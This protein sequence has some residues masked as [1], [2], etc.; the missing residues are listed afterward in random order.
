MIV[1][2]RGKLIQKKPTDI[3][4]DVGGLGYFCSISTNTY[5]HL[6]NIGNEVSL[7]TYFHVMETN[8]S[9]FAFSLYNIISKDPMLI[10]L[11]T[12]ICY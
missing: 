3:I 2:I 7:L 11:T 9:L 12:G 8:Q 10:E 4:I 1:N 6:P 5:D